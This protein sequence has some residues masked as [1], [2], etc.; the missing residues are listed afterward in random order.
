MRYKDKKVAVLRQL[1]LEEEPV[2]LP[3]LMEKMGKGYAERSVRRWLARMVADGSV[4]MLG[5]KRAT[6]YLAV[7][8]KV[9]KKGDLFSES[10]RVVDLFRRPIDEIRVRYRRHRREIIRN[11]ILDKLV[12]DRMRMYLD[13]Q[14]DLLI[15]KKDQAAFWEDVME[16]LHEMDQNRV[17][18]TDITPK[19]LERWLKMYRLEKSASK[20]RLEL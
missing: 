16:D 12:G 10:S 15:P 19:E 3:E 4:E 7:E 6:K 11:I 18:G 1:S 5:R 2:S 8:S 20:G 17:I 9:R 14:T 13:S